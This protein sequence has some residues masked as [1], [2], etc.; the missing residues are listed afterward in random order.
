MYRLASR[1]SFQGRFG[2]AGYGKQIGV[3]ITIAIVIA[4][5]LG[6]LA[7][8][9]FPKSVA[10]TGTR[11]V[12]TVITT[13][14]STLTKTTTVTTS[15]S[16]GVS[17]PTAQN[18][19][20]GGCPSGQ[21]LVLLP[22]ANRTFNVT[23]TPSIVTVAQSGGSFNVQVALIPKNLNGSETLMLAANSDIPGAYSATFNSTS[24]NLN[25]NEP[26][27]VQLHVSILGGIQSGTYAMSIIASK[28]QE[29][30]GGAWLVIN[31]GNS[32]ATVQFDQ[33]P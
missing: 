4:S 21:T 29:T 11:V 18:A 6:G 28:Q 2:L 30:Q 26:V 10:P 33:G 13:G 9:S 12:T 5:V 25:P 23:L 7:I 1:N 17:C 14:G 27:Y 19:P 22:F 16:G 31:L 15:L 24:V 8:Y 32:N 20:S 3:G